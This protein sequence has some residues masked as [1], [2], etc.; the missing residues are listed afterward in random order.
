MTLIN[1]SFYFATLSNGVAESK[2]LYLMFRAD[3]KLA[4]NGLK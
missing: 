3:C 1:G 4:R 2:E